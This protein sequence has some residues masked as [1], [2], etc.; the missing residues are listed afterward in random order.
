MCVEDAPAFHV[1]YA[2]G[3]R[4]AVLRVRTLD[5]DG[6]PQTPVRAPAQHVPA[7]QH[8]CET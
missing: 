6:T 7:M 8:R 5:A 3:W 1:F 2:T 4:D